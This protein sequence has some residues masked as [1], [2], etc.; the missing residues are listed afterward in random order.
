MKIFCFAGEEGPNGHGNEEAAT[1]E[2]IRPEESHHADVHDEKED[3]NNKE[4]E[5]IG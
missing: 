2:N 1:V 4:D 5:E 3:N